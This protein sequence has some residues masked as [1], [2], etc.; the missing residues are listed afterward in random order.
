[1]PKVSDRNL[2]SLG[3][4]LL[5]KSLISS[6]LRKRGSMKAFTG[7]GCRTSNYRGIICSHTAGSHGRAE[8]Y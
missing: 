7:T 8:E 5:L 4:L 1:M 3:V 2:T 6:V